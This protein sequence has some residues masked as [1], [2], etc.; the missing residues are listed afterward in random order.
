MPNV[1]SSYAD[2]HKSLESDERAQ[3][4]VSGSKLILNIDCSTNE[5]DGLQVDKYSQNEATDESS[6]RLSGDQGEDLPVQ[7]GFDL[8]RRSDATLVKHLATLT[9]AQSPS[10]SLQLEDEAQLGLLDEL[11]D[12]YLVVVRATGELVSEGKNLTIAFKRSR[13]G[14]SEPALPSSSSADQHHSQGAKRSESR[15]GKR[16]IGVEFS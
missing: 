5:S 1:S 14:Q 7:L 2:V 15:A 10:V 9:R 11:R 3:T 4:A 16:A 8:Y 6:T 12:E 13:S